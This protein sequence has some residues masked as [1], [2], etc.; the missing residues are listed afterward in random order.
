MPRRIAMLVS[1]GFDLLDLTGPLETFSLANSIAPES[2]LLEVVSLDG[3]LVPS[4]TGLSVFTSV[5]EARGLD[6]LFVIAGP[7]SAETPPPDVVGFVAGAADATRRIAS[8]CVGA[9]ILAAAGLL[10]GKS[11]TTH[12]AWAAK[13]QAR[14]PGARVDGD[15]IFTCEGGIWTSAGISTG[16]DLALAMI[17]DDLGKAVSRAVARFLVVYQRRTGGQLQYSSLLDNEPDSD[18]IRRVLTYARENLHLSL[19]VAD[20]AEVANLSARQ[21]GRAFVAATRSTPAKAVERLRVEA[22]RPRVEDGRETLD[23]IAHSLGFHDA[24]Q[25]RKGFVRVTGQTPQALRR[26]ARA[27]GLE[28]GAI[29]PAGRD[30]R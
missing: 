21:F 11:V 12:W 19:T 2:Y 14:H 5:A 26:L 13:L 30:L 18:R 29:E 10:D 16:I 4:Q 17:E 1:P 3:G 28:D 27:R 22:A 6:T 23:E 25:M 15:R 8:V 20:L 24:V 7:V 9:F